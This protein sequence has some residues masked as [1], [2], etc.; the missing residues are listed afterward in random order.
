MAKAMGHGKGNGDGESGGDPSTPTSVLMSRRGA[1]RTA[2][3]TDW[4]QVERA[5]SSSLPLSSPSASLSLLSSSPLSVGGIGGGRYWYL[6]HAANKAA[7]ARN[8]SGRRKRSASKSSIA[9]PWW[10]RILSGWTPVPN[11]P[12]RGWKVAN[13]KR[14]GGGG[15]GGD[16]I[17][18]RP[19]KGASHCCPY[20]RGAVIAPFRFLE[21]L[22]FEGFVLSC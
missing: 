6:P 22:C 19:S 15:G 10:G 2:C 13:G 8:T 12:A 20:C 3:R 16:A 5:E 7:T 17:C 21:R 4:R 18:G 1:T 11:G 14:T 9:S